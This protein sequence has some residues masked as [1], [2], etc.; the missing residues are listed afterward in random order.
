[1]KTFIGK[2]STG[3]KHIIISS[4]LILSSTVAFGDPVWIDVRSQAEYEKGHIDGD[5]LITHTEIG[6]RI[7]ELFPD[8]ETEIHLYCE[9]GGR[10]ADA[11]Y[12]LESLGYTNVANEGGIR[13]VLNKRNLSITNKRISVSEP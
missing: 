1:M 11:K 6:K 13:D 7:T 2:L 3:V 8:K 12:T 5:L 9:K 4:L 10:A